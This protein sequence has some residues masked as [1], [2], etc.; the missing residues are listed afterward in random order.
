MIF[1]VVE[2]F[3]SLEGEGSWMGRQSAFVRLFGCNLRCDWCDTKESY[4]P[5]GRCEELALE[6]IVDRIRMLEVGFVTLTGGEPFLQEQLPALCAALIEA[7]FR[8]KI[9]TNGTLWQP[10]MDSL[11]AGS[12][13]IACSPKPEEYAVH[14]R[15]A[16]QVNELK[17]VVD[18]RLRVMDVLR[19]PFYEAYKRGV[20]FVL[21]L[22]NNDPGSLERALII[23][24]KLFLL[25]YEARVLPQLHKLLSI[26]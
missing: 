10:G 15:I 2:I 14:P 6:T 20:P 9:E 3:A 1:P 4:G 13:F 25:G 26:A 11:P 7:G 5:G 17:F 21:Q 8:V 23:Q 16:E 19:E 24:K 12:V 22:E 18:E